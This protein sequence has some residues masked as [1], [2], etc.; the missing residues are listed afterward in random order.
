MHPTKGSNTSISRMRQSECRDCE[1][2]LA[3]G[4]N[5][6]ANFRPVNLRM[7]TQHEPAAPRSQTCSYPTEQT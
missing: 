6:N 3:A 5:P 4:A 7:M 1:K 2:L